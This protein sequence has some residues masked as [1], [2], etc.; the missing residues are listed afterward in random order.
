[1]THLCDL[2]SKETDHIAIFNKTLASMKEATKQGKKIDY[3]LGYSNFTFEL[4]II[5]HKTDCNG[6]FTHR[7][8]YLSPLNKAF[9]ERFLEL[10]QY[11]READFNRIL[12]KI[13]LN[14]VKDAIKRSK[15]IMQQNHDNGLRPRLYKGFQYY[16][17][18]PSLTIGESIAKI[19]NDCKLL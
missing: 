1:M 5:L 11:K 12:S 4:W 18:N 13:S 17:E 19:L 9:Q 7:T 14:D 16:T 2:E 15:F 3:F 8:H 10:E 6:S